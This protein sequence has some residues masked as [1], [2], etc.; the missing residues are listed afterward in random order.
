M[1]KYMIIAVDQEGNEV[2]LEHY[3]ENKEKNGI[4]FES[5]EQA[6]TFYDVVKEELF[7]Y[8]VKMLGMQE[9]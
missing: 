4:I 1:K 3:M 2:G 8:S 5:K 9:S 6:C 7:P